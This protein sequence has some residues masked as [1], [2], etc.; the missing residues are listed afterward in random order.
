L[1]ALSTGVRATLRARALAKP[2]P[3]LPGA[4][5]S[6]YYGALFS[7]AGEPWLYGCCFLGSGL[8]MLRTS[9][10]RHYGIAPE[11][12]PDVGCGSDCLTTSCCGTC[13]ACQLD[14]T[15]DEMIKEGNSMANGVPKS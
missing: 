8:G 4:P 11:G 13:A 6:L 7:K 9:V 14:L 1:H 3:S 12:C 5:R 10:R 15:L 2:P